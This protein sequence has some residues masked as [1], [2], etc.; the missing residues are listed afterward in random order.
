MHD[1]FAL[2]NVGI[3]SQIKP[4]AQINPPTYSRCASVQQATSVP[5]QITPYSLPLPLPIIPLT[6][7]IKP[8]QTSSPNLVARPKQLRNIHIERTVRL[9]TSKQLVYTRQSRRDS[10]RGCPSGLEQIEA[11]LARLEIDVGVADRCYE[12]DGRWREG[13]GGGDRDGK[14]P[15]A[16]WEVLASEC[17]DAVGGVG[18]VCAGLCVPSYAVPSTPFMTALHCITSSSVGPSS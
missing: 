17:G 16:V 7:S 18:K 5:N 14:E 9:S 4:N 10:I 2:S 3:S 6:N 15:A 8:N 13:V 12:A 11:D 1:A